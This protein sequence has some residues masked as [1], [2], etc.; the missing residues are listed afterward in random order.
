MSRD[1]IPRR[2]ADLLVWAQLNSAK[3]TASPATFFVTAPIAS[4]YAALVASYAAAFTAARADTGR[5][6]HASGDRWPR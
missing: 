1:F 3:L 5:T 2:D 6:G 4:A